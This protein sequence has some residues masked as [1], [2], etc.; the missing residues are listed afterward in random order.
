[1]KIFTVKVHGAVFTLF[2]CMSA[3]L[4]TGI[5]GQELS[6]QALARWLDRFPKADVNGDG[7]LTNEEL[8]AFRARQIPLPSSQ[9]TQQA[10]DEKVRIR[11]KIPFPTHGNVSYGRDDRHRMDLWIPELTKEEERA[12]RGKGLPLVLFFHGG[13]FVAG[14]KTVFNPTPFLKEKIACVS[15]NYRFVN[16]TTVQSPAPMQDA[17]LAVQVLRLN[18]KKYGIDPDQFI[19]MGNSAGGVIALWLAYHS[20]LRQQQHGGTRAMS[21]RMQ[22]AVAAITPTNLMPDWIRKNVG[23]DKMH[24]SFQKLFGAEMPSPIPL[25]LGQRI[26]QINPWHH[27]TQDDPP[28]YLLYFGD[29]E[30]SVPV[31]KS[32]SPERVVH[33]H[34]FGV[35][36]KER[37]DSLGIQ[38]ELEITAERRDATSGLVGFVVDT[39]EKARFERQKP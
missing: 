16:G 14:D 34:Q 4:S 31:P 28:T 2:V 39:F 7:L 6:E 37:L 5:S 13:G 38:A 3:L 30:A 18:A 29:P 11:A 1:M 36:L 22:G 12:R 32:A 8:A 23:G 17:A 24:P 21:T 33:H 27:L 26:N 20:D 19:A 15:I 25:A 35:A 9:Q 10:R